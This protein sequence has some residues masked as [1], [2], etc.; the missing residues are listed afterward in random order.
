MIAQPRRRLARFAGAGLFA[1]A[2][3][4]G[5][6]PRPELLLQPLPPRQPPRAAPWHSGLPPCSAPSVVDGA[7]WNHVADVDGDGREDFLE[8]TC[9]AASGP[10]RCAMKLCLTAETGLLVAGAWVASTAEVVTPLPSAIVPR[11]FEA[12]SVR[13]AVDAPSPR[14]VA[15]RR[16][17]W[18][19]DGYL[20][21]DERRCGCERPPLG[22]GTM[23]RVPCAGN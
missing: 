21:T 18:S 16:F 12:F 14:C 11:D 3:A 23:M 9:E 4:C 10:A 7:Q 1:H 2:V 6:G 20:G 13:P 22:R 5:S 15:A 19:R 17:I 8:T